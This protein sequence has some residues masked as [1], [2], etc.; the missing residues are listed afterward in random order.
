MYIYIY[1]TAPPGAQVLVDFSTQAVE[2]RFCA[3]DFKH[4]RMGLQSIMARSEMS[5]Y[6]TLSKSDF[7]RIGLL[8]IIW[9]GYSF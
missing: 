2:F 3:I 4:K 5:P 8:N 9:L 1:A 7:T 6:D